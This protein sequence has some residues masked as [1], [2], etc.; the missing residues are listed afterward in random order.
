MTNLRFFENLKMN[1]KESCEDWEQGCWRGR[2]G[3]GLGKG[4]VQNE[5]GVDGHLIWGE[6]VQRDWG[7]EKTGTGSELGL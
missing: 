4:R 5:E 1:V 2:A 7:C 3:N 6:R